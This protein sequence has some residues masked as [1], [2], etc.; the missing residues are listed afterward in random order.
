MPINKENVM[1][2]DPWY[3]RTEF[4]L[5]AASLV[6]PFVPGLSPAIQA[7]TTILSTVSPAVYIA[8]RSF[9]KAKRENAK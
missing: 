7:A 2:N 9:V 4:W 8:G 3:K 6:S 5:A 1:Q